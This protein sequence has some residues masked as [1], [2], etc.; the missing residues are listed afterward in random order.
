MIGRLVHLVIG[1]AVG[2]AAA[3]LL[4]G[5]SQPVRSLVELVSSPGAVQLRAAPTEQPKPATAKVEETPSIKLTNEQVSAAEITLVAAQS[6]TLARRLTV[7][8]TVIPNA[9]RIARVAV[10]LSGTVAELRKKLGEPVVEGEV[11]AIL[12]SRQVADAKSEY[13]AARLTSEL[14][15]DL[16]VR[17][18]DLWDRRIVSEQQY[19]RSRN[20]AAQSRMRR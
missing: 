12:E 20:L 6:A 8:G 10:K 9:D 11:L 15:Q 2:A 17:D 1:I 19:L 14:Q 18:K 7:P 13:L 5:L 16:L 4:L 3:G